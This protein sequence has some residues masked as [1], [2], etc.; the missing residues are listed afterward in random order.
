MVSVAD[1]TV[2][3][4]GHLFAASVCNSGPA[5]NISLL[6]TMIHSEAAPT[7]GVLKRKCSGNIQR[8]IGKPRFFDVW[9]NARKNLQLN[10]FRSTFE[11]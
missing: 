8:I 1:W 9:R 7:I 11:I 4:F 2:F 3:N 5:P 6:D 10:Y